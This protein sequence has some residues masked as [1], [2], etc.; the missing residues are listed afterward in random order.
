MLV[1]SPI[2]RRAVSTR[3]FIAHWRTKQTVG[4]SL[5]SP[6][7][8]SCHTGFLGGIPGAPA[9]DSQPR[10][11]KV[12]IAEGQP[13]TSLPTIQENW[14]ALRSGNLVGSRHV[15]LSRSCDQTDGRTCGFGLVT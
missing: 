12:F 6:D 15:E 3:L 4:S 1:F 11:P 13:A 8:T 10:G 5:F 7:A 14:S 2:L 9:G